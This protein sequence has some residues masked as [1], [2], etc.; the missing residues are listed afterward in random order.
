MS[1]FIEAKNLT[2]EPYAATTGVV[3]NAGANP[4]STSRAFL[5]GDGRG[6]FAGIEWKW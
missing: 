3:A 2:D 6:V 1:W 4:E 5:P